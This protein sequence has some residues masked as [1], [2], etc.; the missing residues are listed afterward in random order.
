[1]ISSL[2][3]RL[4]SKHPDHLEVIVGGVGFKLLVP[5]STAQAMPPNGSEVTLYTSMQVR[6]NAIDLIG[7]ATQ[8]EREVF[9]MLI[10]V[11]GIGVKL[12]LTILSGIK[13]D[14]LLR[15]IIEEDKSLLST[16][17]GIGPKTSG[18][19]VLE[20]KDKVTKIISTSG[21]GV[22]PKLGHVEEAVLALE[23]LG[24]SRYEARKAVEAAVAAIGSNQGSDALI[25][26]ALQAGVR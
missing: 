5:I 10:Q 2:T 20:L 17:S 7:F 18:R 6:E 24:Y 21:I 12:A 9:E 26:A 8:S 15:S 4:S 14:D 22:T 3:G 1:M 25:R 13:V 23:A 19:L 16:I 11:S